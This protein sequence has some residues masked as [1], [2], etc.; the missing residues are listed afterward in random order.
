MVRLLRIYTYD[1]HSVNNLSRQNRSGPP[2]EFALCSGKVTRCGECYRRRWDGVL[3][4]KG[5][6]VCYSLL[7]CG[8][9]H[10]V[11]TT[12]LDTGAGGEVL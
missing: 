2:H 10:T 6:G 5:T 11:P 7:T 9:I 12:P 4:S 3:R 8:T 1:T